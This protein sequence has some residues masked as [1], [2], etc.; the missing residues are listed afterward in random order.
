MFSTA[1]RLRPGRHLLTCVPSSLLTPAARAHAKKHEQHRLVDHLTPGQGETKA[2]LARAPRERHRWS[3]RL[4]GRRRACCRWPLR[5]GRRVTR[6]SHPRP[7]WRVKDGREQGG[8]RGREKQRQPEQRGLSR[9]SHS[10]PLAFENNPQ[11]HVGGG[12]PRQIADSHH[13]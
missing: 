10:S 5:S 9:C 3:G 11:Q 4:S 2:G 8:G 1:T 13:P 7:T 6:C 12:A